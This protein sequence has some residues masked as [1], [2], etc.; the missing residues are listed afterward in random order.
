MSIGGILLLAVAV[1][2]FKF[3]ALGVDPFQAFVSGLDEL[4]PLNFGTVYLLV[5][6]YHIDIAFR[7]E[8]PVYLLYG[9]A[10]E[11]LS[12]FVSRHTR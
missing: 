6:T 1:T 3:A 8:L 11:I 5:K 9:V 2:F 12:V 10:R 4:S 7:G